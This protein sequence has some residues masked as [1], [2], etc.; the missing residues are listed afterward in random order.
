MIGIFLFHQHKRANH[1]CPENDG[2]EIED[3]QKIL[4]LRSYPSR[5]FEEI[6][7][8]IFYFCSDKEHYLCF[9]KNQII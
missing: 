3:T 5:R 6:S 4:S 2:D 8:R 7:G 9:I 1:R